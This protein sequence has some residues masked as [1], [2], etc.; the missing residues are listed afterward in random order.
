MNERR[1]RTVCRP[2]LFSIAEQVQNRT[3][4]IK[5]PQQKKR[6]DSEKSLNI[7]GSALHNRTVHRPLFRQGG[8][9]HRHEI[10][11]MKREDAVSLLLEISV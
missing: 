11:N 6:C 1:F 9:A 4:A 3:F 5:M 8:G 7:P 2:M 10:D